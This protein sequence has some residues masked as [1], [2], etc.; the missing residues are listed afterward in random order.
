MTIKVGHAVPDFTAPS[1]LGDIT[2][3][4]LKG[5]KV[6]LYFYPK[7]NTPGCT[8]EGQNF[9]DL[10][11]QFVKNNTAVI[12]ISRDSIK[13]HQNFCEQ[14]KFQFPLVS[15]VA[16]QLTRMFD[17]IKTKTMYGKPVQG[18]ERSTFVIDQYG[19]L[20]KEWRSVKVPGHAEEVLSFIKNL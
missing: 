4:L 2:L 10:H 5:H 13:S 11:D 18:V 16:E 12:G 3:S 8:L 9:R 14:E 1:T 20:A 15:D 6:V 19:V 17:V 7:D